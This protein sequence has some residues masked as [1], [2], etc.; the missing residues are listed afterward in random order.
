MTGCNVL[1]K[2]LAARMEV[3]VSRHIPLW[4]SVPL[5]VALHYGP[6]DNTLQLSL[7]PTVILWNSFSAPNDLLQLTLNTDLS[8]PAAASP[9]S[10]PFVMLLLMKPW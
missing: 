8:I 9:P 2:G 1:D 7:L 5:R 3:R 4:L 10:S 6:F